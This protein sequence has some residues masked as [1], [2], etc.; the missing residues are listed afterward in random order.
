MNY[1][2]NYRAVI[3]CDVYFS[4]NN[5]KGCVYWLIIELHCFL[6]DSGQ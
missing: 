1:D 3:T 6:G 5:L 4:I 2:Y